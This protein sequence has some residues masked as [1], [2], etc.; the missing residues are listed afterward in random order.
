MT[1]NDSRVPDMVARLEAGA[2]LEDVA[3][4]Y[5]L[6]RERVR[7]ITKGLYDRNKQRAARK[8]SH[9]SLVDMYKEEIMEDWFEGK[10]IVQIAHELGLPCGYAEQ[11]LREW[12]AEW[13]PLELARRRSR[14]ISKSTQKISDEEIIAIIRFIAEQ[15][16]HAPSLTDYDR[17]RE[18][19]SDWPSIPTLT[20][21]SNK[22]FNDL[23]R[24]AGFTPNAR[25]TGMGLPTFDDA[26]VFAALNAVRDIVGHF[27]SITEYTKH[28]PDGAISEPG[29]R[30]KFGSWTNAME[31][32]INHN[33]QNS[34]E[35]TP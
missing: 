31:A 29:I 13:D 12:T 32:L 2:T 22:S 19:F 15:E 33:A 5:N 9:L 18:H 4:V 21:R 27:P 30:R 26:H 28:R 10:G 7:Q 25:P 16:G 17:W 14:A 35:E 1:T 11:R 3:A 20:T 8:N 24:Q 23:V 34:N 6:T